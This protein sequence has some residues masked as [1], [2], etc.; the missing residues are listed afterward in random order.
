MKGLLSL[1]AALTMLAAPGARALDTTPA[2]TLEIPR[3]F[4]ID[5]VIEAVDRSTIAAQTSAQVEEILFDVDDFV[6]QDAVIV[7]L[8]NTEQKAGAEQAAANLRAARARLTQAEAEH[9]RFS[10]LFDR[11][12]VSRQ[13][14]DRVTAALKTAR[15]GYEAAQAATSQA[16]QQLEYTRVRAPYAGIVTERHVEVGEIAQPGTPLMSGISLERLRVAVAVP[17]SLVGDVRRYRSARVELPDGGWIDALD[18]TVFPV[19]DAASSSFRTRIALP[20]G[21]DGLF[22]GMVVRVA[23]VTGRE[24]VLLVPAASLVTRSEV[25]GVYVEDAGGAIHF[26]HVRAGKT[27][28]DGRVALLSGL[29]EGERVAL[30]PAAALAA[31]KTTSGPA[32]E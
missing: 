17:Q 19:A 30:D 5:G 16:G 20:T 1:A 22:P 21:Q 24:R 25:T 27:L 23:F 3:H 10:D 14:M 8:K 13:E 6:E 9:Q 11:Q 15:A 28:E 26:R 32:H 7:V 31:L 4:L 12:L 2:V 29:E 18:L